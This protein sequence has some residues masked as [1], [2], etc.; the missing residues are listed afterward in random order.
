MLQQR[1][2]LMT[3]STYTVSLS[4]LRGM[5]DK[6][7]SWIEKLLYYEILCTRFGT[8]LQTFILCSEFTQSIGLYILV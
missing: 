3:S 2:T 7:T 8:R 1:R 6:K 5:T 4:W